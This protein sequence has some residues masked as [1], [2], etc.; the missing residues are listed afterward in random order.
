MSG[1][2]A[3]ATPSPAPSRSRVLK[4]VVAAAFI[5]LAAAAVVQ[6]IHLLHAYER[7]HESR[8]TGIIDPT[9]TDLRDW[10]PLRIIARRY[11]VPEPELED[12]LRRAGFVVEPQAVAPDLPDA[13]RRFGFGPPASSSPAERLLPPDR[14]SL[15][16]IAAH[17]GRDPAQAVAVVRA[18]ILDYR[19][20]HPPARQA[21]PPVSPHDPPAERGVGRSSASFGAPAAPEMAGRPSGAGAPGATG[22]R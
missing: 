19:A 5:V 1:S 3:V 11:H 7:L 4:V 9:V 20:A 13:L 15:R 12:A 18:A 2:T 10:M 16:Q 14:Q 6:A 22:S 17:S 8:T 21:P